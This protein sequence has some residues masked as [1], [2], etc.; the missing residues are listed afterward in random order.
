MWRRDRNRAGG[1]AIGLDGTGTPWQRR[2]HEQSRWAWVVT[3]RADRHDRVVV[4]TIDRAATRNAVDGPT[5]EALHDIFSSFDTDPSL[6]AAVLTGAGGTFCSGADLRAV[7]AGRGNRIESDMSK[8][9]PL[10]CTRLVL[11]KPVVAAVEGYAVAGGL[12]LA[13]WCD[14]RVV[15]GDAIFGVFCRRWGVPL[16]DGGTVRLPRIVGQG[17]ALDM[18]LTGRPVA[19]EEALAWGLANRVVPPGTTLEVALTLATTIA[20]FPQLCLRSD[21]ISTYQQWGLDLTGAMANEVQHGLVPVRA[22]ETAAGA[23]RF[24]DGAGRHGTGI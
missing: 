3:V 8:P 4:V 23:S 12:E 22:G 11:S 24:A 5:A 14:L 21:R 13:L 16:V 17:R 10:G 7:G 15:A 1:T 18:I 2:L 20:E 6:D 19:A 9:G